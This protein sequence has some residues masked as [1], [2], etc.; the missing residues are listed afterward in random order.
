M[1]PGSDAAARETTLSRRPRRPRAVSACRIPRKPLRS[2]AELSP[3]RVKATP[4]FVGVRSGLRDPVKAGSRLRGSVCVRSVLRD[5]VCVRSVLRVSVCVRSALCV[6]V[7]VRSVLRV[8]VCVPSALR[9]PV[10]VRSVLRD[11]VCVPSASTWTRHALSD[12]LRSLS[13]RIGIDSFS[14]LGLVRVAQ[15]PPAPLPMARRGNCGFGR[16]GT[17]VH[18]LF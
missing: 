8:S 10:C 18:F 7:C 9:R 2:R 14:C 13:G 17:I 5:P 12:E 3:Q 4:D 1:G 11:S 16:L 6:P 15:P